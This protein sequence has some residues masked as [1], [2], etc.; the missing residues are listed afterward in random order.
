[1]TIDGAPFLSESICATKRSS[2][3]HDIGVQLNSER[4][5][6]LPVN[7]LDFDDEAGKFVGALLEHF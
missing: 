6:G 7:A 5:I 3:L 2:L 4:T 1:M